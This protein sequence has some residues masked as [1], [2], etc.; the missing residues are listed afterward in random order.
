[1]SKASDIQKGLVIKFKD[2]PHLVVDYQHVNPGKGAAFIRSRL[3]SLKTGKVIENTFKVEEPV[4]FIDLERKK[5]QYLYGTDNEHAFMDMGTYEQFSVG[6]DVMGQY[7]PYLKEGLE[8]TLLL[9][10]GAPVTVDFPKKV[11]LKVIEAPPG[12]RGDTATNVTKEIVLENG[13]KVRT[14]LFIK[15][16]D[17]VIINTDTGEYVER[18]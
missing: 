13:L 4:E 16:G 3:K 12:V 2:E 8:I 1:M 7:A 17:T 15:E 18:D 11:V 9:S 6:A 10:D 14:P 5:V